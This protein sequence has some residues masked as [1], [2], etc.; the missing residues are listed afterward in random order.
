MAETDSQYTS[1]SYRIVD[2]M[3]YHGVQARASNVDAIFSVP[4]DLMDSVLLLMPN[5]LHLYVFGKVM[6][7]YCY[8][9]QLSV[10]KRMVPS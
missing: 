4:A 7:L 6:V 1:R 8:S 3:G 9:R 10:W 5:R 2:K